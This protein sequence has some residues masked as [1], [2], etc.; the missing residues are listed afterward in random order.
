MKIVI[1]TRGSTLAR[2]QAKIAA[3][4]LVAIDS[5]LVI[6]TRIISTSGDVNQAPIPLD[7]NGK[8]WFTKEIE[9]ELL[10]GTIDIAVH[11]LKDLADEPPEGLMLAAYLAREDARDA[12][13]TKGNVPMEKLIV[14][15]IVGTDS[16][17]RKV[18]LNLLRPDLKVE[19]VR[20]NVPTR[21][22]KMDAG[23]YDALVLAAAG[24]KRLGLEER[25]SRYFTQQEM[26][27]APGQGILALQIRANHP[28]LQVLLTKVDD[29]AASH[30]AQIERSF[31]R[32]I[33]GGCKT[34]TASYAWKE[35]DTC[36]VIGMTLDSHGNIIRGQKDMAWSESERIGETLAQELL[37]RANA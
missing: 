2:T 26:T 31:S 17:R 5:T 32:A 33:G 6:E 28:E 16:E 36:H 8:G 25:V 7:T 9:D 21:L 37:A 11:S 4:A 3:A 19:S 35:H 12:L 24:L 30:A 10:Q 20:G 29:E 22:A 15:A 27:S 34:P 13:V 18:Q 1:G 23:G 14:G